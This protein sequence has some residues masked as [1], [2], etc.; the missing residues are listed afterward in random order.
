L[1]LRGFQG[2]RR[3]IFRCLQRRFILRFSFM[4]RVENR[5]FFEILYWKLSFFLRF[6][7]RERC[8]F[9]GWQCVENQFIHGS[10]H[11]ECSS[12]I[13]ENHW[14]QFGVLGVEN[15]VFFEI[16]D[17]KLPKYSTLAPSALADMYFLSRA[18]GAPKVNSFVRMRVWHFCENARKSPSSQS[19]VTGTESNLFF[20]ILGW[21]LLNFL[22]SPLRSSQICIFS[23]GI[24]VRLESTRSWERAVGKSWTRES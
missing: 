5:V 11:L 1:V 8:S 7:T 24:H 6:G 9:L 16:F 12:K 18:T 15:K 21:K 4:P 10:A 14:V 3:G 19:Q 22:C 23:L 20:A 13:R 17:W 2:L